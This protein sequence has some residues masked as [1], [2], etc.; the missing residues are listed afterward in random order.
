MLVPAPEVIGD[1]AD[2]LRPSKTRS[3]RFQSSPPR[4]LQTRWTLPAASSPSAVPRKSPF[5]SVSR[6]GPDQPEALRRRA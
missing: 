1:L 4:S 2:Q 3:T 5:E 6:S